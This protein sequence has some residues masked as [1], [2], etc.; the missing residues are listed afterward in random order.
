LYIPVFNNI[1]SQETDTDSNSKIVLKVI[2]FVCNMFLFEDCNENEEEE[3]LQFLEI[4]MYDDHFI[5]NFFNNV[6]FYFFLLPV[7]IFLK[8]NQSFVVLSI[9]S[10]SYSIS[11]LKHVNDLLDPL[12]FNFLL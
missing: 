11:Y 6:V 10:S 2:I 1:N 12:K 9:S 5:I 7:I 8:I 4:Y 3:R